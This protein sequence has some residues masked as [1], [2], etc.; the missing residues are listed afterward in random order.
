M[1]KIRHFIFF[2]LKHYIFFFKQNF[3]NLG[4]NINSIPVLD[5]LKKN[6]SKII[7]DRSFSKDKK[8]VQEVG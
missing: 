8:I 6:T 4:I 7:G 2:Y 1:T 5:I 3:R